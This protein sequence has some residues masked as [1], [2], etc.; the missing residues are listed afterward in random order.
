MTRLEALSAF[1]GSRRTVVVD[2]GH[3]IRLYEPPLLLLYASSKVLLYAVFGCVVPA[4]HSHT[5]VCVH[6]DR[7]RRTNCHLRPTTFNSNR[8]V[9][10]CQ[11]AVPMDG[12][13]ASV[14]MD[15]CSAS[16][17]MDGCSASV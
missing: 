1:P 17:P 15:G 9:T 7:C 6:L 3:E 16:V 13:S 10:H 4:R 14:P 8:R 5:S 2:H 12:C 11:S